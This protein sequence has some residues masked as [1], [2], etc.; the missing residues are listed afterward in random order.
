MPRQALPINTPHQALHFD[1]NAMPAQSVTY[2]DNHLANVRHIAPTLDKDN[3]YDGIAQTV[4]LAL[5]ET[6][7]K[8]LIPHPYLKQG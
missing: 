5:V 3:V 1:G 6:G 4:Q 7:I 8:K 2:A